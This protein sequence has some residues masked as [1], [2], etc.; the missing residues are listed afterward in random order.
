MHKGTFD[1]PLGFE[2]VEGMASQQFDDSTILHT[3]SLLNTTVEAFA[4][5]DDS[6]FQGTE[7]TLVRRVPW[8]ND[9]LHFHRTGC[10]RVRIGEWGRQSGSTVKAEICFVIRETVEA[11]RMKS[12]STGPR[13]H[14]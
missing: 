11:T 9:S 1:L 5:L 14:R 10:E 6:F 3:L 7:M 12:S 4:C 2:S 8:L 13:D